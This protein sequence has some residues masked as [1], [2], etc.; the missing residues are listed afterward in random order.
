MG[1]QFNGANIVRDTPDK[2]WMERVVMCPRHGLVLQKH[3]QSHS[4]SQGIA[5]MDRYLAE[6]PS[7]RYAVLGQRYAEGPVPSQ[8]CR[9]MEM[10]HGDDAK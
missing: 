5:P 4:A 6:R 9:C 10:M 3:V 1:A 7:Q 8:G 2:E